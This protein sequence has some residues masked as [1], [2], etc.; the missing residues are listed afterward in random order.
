MVTRSWELGEW[1]LLSNGYG[2]SVW[3]DGKVLEMDVGGDCTTV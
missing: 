1:E 3:E 2:V